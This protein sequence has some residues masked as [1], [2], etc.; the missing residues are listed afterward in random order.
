MGKITEKEYS[1]C[2]EQAKLVYEKK[3]TKQDVVNFLS[4]KDGLGMKKSSA[5]YYVNAYL[6]MRHGEKYT[7]TINNDATVYYLE[8]I[9]SD[10][11]KVALKIALESLQKH[12]DYYSKQGKGALKL[13]QV[14][15]DHFVDEI[16]NK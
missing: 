9:N 1:V 14:L 5:T 4:K 8:H 12:L 2:Y 6:N 7:K 16:V 3:K 13:L 15:H 10:N 11:G